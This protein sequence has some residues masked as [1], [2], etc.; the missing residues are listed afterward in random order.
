MVAIA[1]ISYWA[2]GCDFLRSASTIS[3]CTTARAERRVP[4]WIV[5]VVMPAS[6]DL[7]LKAVEGAASLEDHSWTEVVGSRGGGGEADSSCSWVAIL[8][9]WMELTLWEGFEGSMLFCGFVGCEERLVVGLLKKKV[10]PPQARR[11]WLMS[12]HLGRSL[13]TSMHLSVNS[14]R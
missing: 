6:S 10:F 13:F 4:M 8:K 5:V 11:F 1:W 9:R 2:S 3:A 12:H 7:R 14:L